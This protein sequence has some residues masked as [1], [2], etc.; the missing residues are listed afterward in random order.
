MGINPTFPGPGPKGDP[1][2]LEQGEAHNQA[3]T[4]V[5]D[6]PF[7]LDSVVAP[8]VDL[9][10][11]AQLLMPSLPNLAGMNALMKVKSRTVRDCLEDAK[12]QR[13]IKERRITYTLLPDGPG[14]VLAR[15]IDKTM[16]VLYIILLLATFGYNYSRMTA[17]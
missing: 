10:E 13:R 4:A 1:G 16:R 6:K 8:V 9:A 3:R 2:P 15:K 5:T 11:R 12:L 14:P 7:S 17:T